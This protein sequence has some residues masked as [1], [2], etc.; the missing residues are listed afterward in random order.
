VIH[1]RRG[2]AP[3]FHT[4]ELRLSAERNGQHAEIA[5]GGAEDLV[6]HTARRAQLVRA[7]HRHG[8]LVEQRHARDL[9]RIRRKL[10]RGGGLHPVGN[11]D[12][13]V[14]GNGRGENEQRD[15]GGALHQALAFFSTTAS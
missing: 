9:V 5:A 6:G 2:D 12:R 7:L 15:G 10:L 13:G 4:R 1:A 8:G 11:A 14:R 3:P